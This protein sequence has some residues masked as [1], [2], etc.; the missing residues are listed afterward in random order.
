MF[1]CR[2]GDT[3]SMPIYIM[4]QTLP[5]SEVRL[6]KAYFETEFERYEKR[7]W[8]LAQIAMA[9]YK[10]NDS[11]KRSYK[12]RDFLLKF[13]LRKNEQKLTPEEGQVRIKSYFKTLIATSINKNRKKAT[14]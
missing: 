6:W 2:L 14:K 11:K 8:Y 3:L 12:L 7:D 1:W 4:K 13:R 9:I 10:S 5:Q